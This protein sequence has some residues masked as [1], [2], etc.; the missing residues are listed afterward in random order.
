VKSEAD[1]ETLVCERA[2]S[3][4]LFSVRVEAMSACQSCAAYYFDY[5]PWMR[6]N[7]A[8]RSLLQEVECDVIANSARDSG[9]QRCA[10]KKLQRDAQ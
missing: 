8:L 4:G 10:E 7:E 3:C 6:N 1:D 2:Q 9:I 5:Y